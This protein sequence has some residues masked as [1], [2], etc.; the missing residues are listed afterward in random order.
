MMGGLMTK[1]TTSHNNPVSIGID[2]H[3]RYSIFCAIDAS[4]R[5]LGLQQASKS[6]GKIKWLIAFA[7]LGE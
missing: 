7:L 5:V 6:H 3:K 2:F 1:P 4:D